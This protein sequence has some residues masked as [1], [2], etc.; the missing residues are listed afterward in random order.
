VVADLTAML[1]G[2]RDTLA[3]LRNRSLLLLGFAGA[4]RRSEL[5][6]LD[7]E[8]LDFTPSGLVVTLR[9]SKTDQEGQGRKV[10][11]P[12]GSRPETCPVSTLK[13][14]LESTDISI[15]PLFREINRGDR[16]TAPYTDKQGRQRGVRLGDKAV[17]LIVKRAAEAAGLVLRNTPVI[18][19]SNA[20][21]A[22]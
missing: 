13:T 21:T 2:Q 14:W 10:G 20:R 7:V 11:V 17:A 6:S 12:Y 8:D 1:K 19:C 9:R 3:G 22:G 15:G 4:L 16:L 18:R 5:A